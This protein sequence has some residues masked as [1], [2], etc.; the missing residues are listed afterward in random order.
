[1][2]RP[3][4]DYFGDEIPDGSSKYDYTEVYSCVDRTGKG[5]RFMTTA[6]GYLGWV[7]DNLFGDDEAQTKKGDLIAII[8]GCTTPLV[9]SP[10]G[11]YFQ[12]VGEA[13]VQGLTEGEAMEV[14]KTGQCLAQDF[15]FC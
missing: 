12:V 1:M 15:T 2:G 14:L 4:D 10:Q 8:F 6:K 13:Y 11:E 5:R 9:I 3:V 7:P